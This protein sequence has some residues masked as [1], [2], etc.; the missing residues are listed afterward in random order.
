MLSF[1]DI[2]KFFKPQLCK[3][4]KGNSYQF[5]VN[6]QQQSYGYND[7]IEIP[8]ISESSPTIEVNN[9]R[10]YF[11]KSTYQQQHGEDRLLITKSS[12]FFPSF[13]GRNHLN[14][15]QPNV[16]YSQSRR[17]HQ[18]YLPS[19]LNQ[20]FLWNTNCS[21]TKTI[22]N[23]KINES[24]LSFSHIPTIEKNITKCCCCGRNRLL[25]EDNN[26]NFG[27]NFNK[28]I[29]PHQNFETLRQPIRSGDSHPEHRIVQYN[30]QEVVIPDRNF[31]SIREVAQERVYTQ[32]NGN[33]NFCIKQ[34]STPDVKMYQRF[35]ESIENC[36]KQQN[37]N[38]LSYD[39]AIDVIKNNG[40]S[41]MS[42]PPTP[43]LA[44]KQIYPFSNTNMEHH[45]DGLNKPYYL[46][47]EDSN[48]RRFHHT[49]NFKNTPF[50]SFRD[51]YDSGRESDCPSDTSLDIDTQELC[52]FVADE[53]KR[54][55]I[56]QSTFARKV[57]NRS[58]GTLSDMLRN[59]KPW[60][61]L[62]T[63]RITF[64]RMHEW[65]CL[66]EKERFRILVEGGKFM[67]P[68]RRR[69]IKSKNKVIKNNMEVNDKP[70]IENEHDVLKHN[71]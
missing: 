49:N 32:Y 66:P 62:K 61:Q 12:I 31:C 36:T 29:I 48:I 17:G 42:R 2:L 56:S 14:V 65:S 18:N 41:Q 20:Q 58:Q 47:N 10:E 54:Y 40:T 9:S 38:N 4:C 55:S 52:R 53:L 27:K 44:R 70:I 33:R 35:D 22:E 59:P 63:G 34:S 39:S 21:S 46:T 64:V 5:H 71:F 50:T 43:L 28:Q 69:R 23:K 68:E 19:K 26:I 16:V 37:L 30:R 6:R 8:P 1:L 7:E 67:A 11:K 51:Q 25:D 24:G 15:T 57:L 60:N 3:K 13:S 45:F